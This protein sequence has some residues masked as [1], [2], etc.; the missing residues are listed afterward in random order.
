MYF[1]IAAQDLLMVIDLVWVSIHLHTWSGIV[2]LISSP[3]ETLLF[4]YNF[5]FEGAEVGI[6]TGR[7]HSRGPVGVEGLLTSKWILQG[8]GNA[9][10]DFS[11]NGNMKYIHEQLAV[12]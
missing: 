12:A 5:F 4:Y 3:L 8:N 7:I 10:A 11:E 6:S 9:V 1:T 2:T